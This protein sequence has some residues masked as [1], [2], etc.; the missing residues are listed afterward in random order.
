M[1]TATN[2]NDGKDYD[3]ID[4][5]VDHMMMSVGIS[6]SISTT[7]PIDVAD[8]RRRQTFMS[9]IM[10]VKIVTI[11]TKLTTVMRIRIATIMTVMTTL[12]IMTQV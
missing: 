7:I 6:V 8:I 4:D 5:N 1:L 9:M 3:E 2:S 10:I 11:M 12:M